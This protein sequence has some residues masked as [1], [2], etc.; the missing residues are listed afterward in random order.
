MRRFLLSFKSV[1][2]ATANGRRNQRFFYRGNTFLNKKELL[3]TRS[4]FTLFGEKRGELFDDYFT[5]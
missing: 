5:T 1:A 4:S 2:Q 3:I